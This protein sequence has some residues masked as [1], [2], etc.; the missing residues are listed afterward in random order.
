MH[1]FLPSKQELKRRHVILES[2]CELC[3]DPDESLCHIVFLCLAAKRFWAEVKNFSGFSVPLLHPTT[4]AID[5]LQPGI[6]SQEFAV[7]LVCGAWSLWSGRNA[8]RHG[9]KAWE[10][11][12]AVH[13]ISNM[14]ED[15]AGMQLPIEKKLQ[16]K[17]ERWQGPEQDWVKVNTDAAST[18]DVG[19]GSSGAVIRNHDPI[20]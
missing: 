20:W 6:C 3:G 13:H 18:V 2:H 4:W 7:L 12:A 5:V 9:R 19:S 8:R 1:N 17:V 15:L 14:L 10:P 11:G 16:K